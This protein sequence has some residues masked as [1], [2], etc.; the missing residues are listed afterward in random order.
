MRN[1][2]LPMS[3]HEEFFNKDFSEYKGDVKQIDDILLIG[4]EF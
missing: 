2:H 1:A 3:E 4:I